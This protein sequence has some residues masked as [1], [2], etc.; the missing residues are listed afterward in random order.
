LVTFWATKSD[1]NL[2]KVNRKKWG[3][4]YQVTLKLLDNDL[5]KAASTVLFVRP[6]GIRF[7]STRHLGAALVRYGENTKPM[8]KMT[9]EEK[10]KRIA[11]LE[12][13]I[14]NAN[15]EIAAILEPATEQAPKKRKGRLPPNFGLKEKVYALI[16]E[17]GVDGKSSKSDIKDEIFKRHA[18]KIDDGQIQGALSNLKADEKIE[19]VGRGIYSLKAQ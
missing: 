5:Q 1:N 9:V 19:I 17:K 13:T 4:I 18:V 8:A 14:R 12:E 15:A 11:E 6:Q 10:R 3:L 7:V 16:L 2:N